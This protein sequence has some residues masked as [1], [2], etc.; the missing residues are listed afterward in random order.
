MRKVA[1]ACAMALALG[2]ISTAT[3]QAEFS[4]AAPIQESSAPGGPLVTESHIA[5]L[6][7]AL[8]LTPEQYRH[9]AP[10]ESALRALAR[11]QR[12]EAGA[13]WVQ[14]MS[15]RAS[16]VAATAIQL[17]RLA[18]AARPLIA[19]LTE[20]QKSSAME[21]IRRHGFERLLAMF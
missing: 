6:K 5:G 15:D 21:V 10:V 17:R 4:S 19:T 11:E 14:R 7:T 2:T 3:A 1:L 12:R 8:R 20:E 16:S 9:W 13:G 18:T